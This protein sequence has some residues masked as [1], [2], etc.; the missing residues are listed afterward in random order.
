MLVAI[1]P[2]LISGERLAADQLLLSSSIDI[3]EVGAALGFFARYSVGALVPITGLHY[4]E[5]EISE[6]FQPVL[7]LVSVES[8]CIALFLRV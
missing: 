1:N 3:G 7:P 2:L 5:T 8:L 6:L 4:H